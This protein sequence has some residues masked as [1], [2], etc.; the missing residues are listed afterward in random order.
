MNKKAWIIVILIAVVIALFATLTNNQNG[1]NDILRGA[2]STIGEVVD[3]NESVT[4]EL[5]EEVDVVDET[6]PKE[7]NALLNDE[8]ANVDGI[9]VMEAPQKTDE[10]APEDI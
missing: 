5:Q 9:E 4:T 2:T 1:N 7:E 6:A 10:V 3:I 8:M